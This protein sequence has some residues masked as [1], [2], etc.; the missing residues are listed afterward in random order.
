M[1]G[2]HVTVD[3]KMKFGIIVLPIRKLRRY[4]HLL[5]AAVSEQ[6]VTHTVSPVRQVIIVITGEFHS[7]AAGTFSHI[8]AE[9]LVFKS[10]YTPRAA[11]EG[12]RLGYDIAFQPV[13][14]PA[15]AML[16][17]EEYGN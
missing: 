5:D 1:L 12:Q 8:V 11:T 17:L 15:V 16:F 4:R 13:R 9:S 7:I 2:E 6:R 3:H 10:I 14:E